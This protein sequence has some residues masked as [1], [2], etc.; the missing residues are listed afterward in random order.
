MTKGQD[1]TVLPWEASKGKINQIKISWLKWVSDCLI[2]HHPAQQKWL[3]THE[4]TWNC[5][6]SALN[7]KEADW[8]WHNTITYKLPAAQNS[9]L[10]QD[11]ALPCGGNLS[12]SSWVSAI[13]SLQLN[14]D[15]Q[16]HES[17][18]SHAVHASLLLCHQ[19][20]LLYASGEWMALGGA[21]GITGNGR[22][23]NPSSRESSRAAAPCSHCTG[24]CWQKQHLPSTAMQRQ[25]LSCC[26]I[27]H[28]CH[29][30]SPL[31]FFPGTHQFTLYSYQCL[32]PI[33]VFWLGELYKA[34]TLC[35]KPRDTCFE[36][37]LTTP[38][39]FS[40]QT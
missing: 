40:T 8:V 21:G 39:H 30:V 38:N 5:P 34:G 11:G 19:R 23:A 15:S 2:K 27:A 32:T 1:L 17:P 33:S 22:N 14:P 29:L 9:L 24:T 37:K 26:W 16:A 28:Q 31:L 6:V 18:K 36:D 35:S 12:L 10:Q 4:T 13:W 3:N 20:K 25:L 7:F